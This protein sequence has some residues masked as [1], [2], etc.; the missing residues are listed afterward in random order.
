MTYVS[1]PMGNRL[2]IYAEKI[3]KKRQELRLDEKGFPL[4]RPTPTAE[5]DDPDD[6]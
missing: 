4:P 6:N 2:G 1:K 3:E 5:N